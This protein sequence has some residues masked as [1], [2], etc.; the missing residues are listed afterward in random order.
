MSSRAPLSHPLSAKRIP[1]LRDRSIG[2]KGI[3]GTIAD[4]SAICLYLDRKHEA[5]LYGRFRC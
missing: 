3:P 4:F 1:V 5:G 2:E